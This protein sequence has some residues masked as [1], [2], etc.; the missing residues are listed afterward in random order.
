MKI[1]IYKNSKKVSEFNLGEIIKEFLETQLA[2]G[3]DGV[4]FDNNPILK[5]QELL[6]EGE[7]IAF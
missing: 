7:K 5:I 4:Q 3:N 1:T 6:E 2:I